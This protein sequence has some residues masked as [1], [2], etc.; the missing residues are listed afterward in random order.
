M[1]LRGRTPS[2]R[3]GMRHIVGPLTVSDMQYIA[4]STSL[5]LG[6]CLPNKGARMAVDGTVGDDFWGLVR[7]AY[8][9]PQEPLLNLNNA[10]VSPPP[11]VVEDAALAALRLVSRNPDVNMWTHLD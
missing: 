7:Q 11:L 9:P 2:W 6:C 3:I 10:A 4:C 1:R 8:P 5:W